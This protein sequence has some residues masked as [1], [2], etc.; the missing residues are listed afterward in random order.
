MGK[1]IDISKMTFPEILQHISELPAPDRQNAVTQISNLKPDLKLL[2]RLVF[3]ESWQFDLPKGAPPYRPLDM[4]ENWGY[5]RLPRELR[6]FHYFIKGA[7][8]NLTK[9]KKEQMFIDVLESV[10][11]EEAKL[12]L[13]IKEKKLEYRGITKRL[14]MKSIPDL[15]P[16]TASDD[17]DTE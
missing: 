16:N 1:T 7:N 5:N 4:P 6:K 9:L 11:P 13:M 15:L 12:V 17:G 2:F 14:I 10:S 8:N 3:D